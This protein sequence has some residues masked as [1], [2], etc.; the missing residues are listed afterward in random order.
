MTIQEQEETRKQRTFGFIGLL[1][2][3]LY[4]RGIK[5]H[6]QTLSDILSDKLNDTYDALC[7]GMVQAVIAASCR[8]SKT[9]Q[10]E[11]VCK[12]VDCV[13]VNA[14]GE[15][16]QRY[17]ELFDKELETSIVFTLKE[18]VDIKDVVDLTYRHWLYYH[19]NAIE[20]VE[21]L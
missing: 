20:A 9:T 7:G 12:A 14:K 18:Y 10:G 3:V 5:I 13:Y 1:A 11:K 4:R 2:V 21:I 17:K 8:W 19:K 15:T 6:Y 16:I